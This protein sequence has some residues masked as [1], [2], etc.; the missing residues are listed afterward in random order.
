MGSVPVLAATVKATSHARG[1]YELTRRVLGLGTN[2]VP[3]RS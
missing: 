1:G 3:S 2:Y